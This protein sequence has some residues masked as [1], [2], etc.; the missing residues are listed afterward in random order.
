MLGADNLDS[1]PLSSS[2]VFGDRPRAR[3]SLRIPSIRIPNTRFDVLGGDCGACGLHSELIIRA[4]R[5]ALQLIF[6][7]RLQYTKDIPP[8]GVGIVW[9]RFNQRLS[10]SLSSPSRPAVFPTEFPAGWTFNYFEPFLVNHFKSAGSLSHVVFTRL[11]IHHSVF[12]TNMVRHHSRHSFRPGSFP[13][14]GFS[15]GRF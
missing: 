10:R 2:P 1:H 15:P 11:D 12:D 8:A 5:P 6:V 4:L 13:R 7:L 3:V 9:D 14:A